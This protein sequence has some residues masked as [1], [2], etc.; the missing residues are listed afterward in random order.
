MKTLSK[1]TSIP[2]QIQARH[3]HFS[4]SSSFTVLPLHHLIQLEAPAMKSENWQ[5]I[6]VLSHI[7]QWCSKNNPHPQCLCS[8]PQQ[9]VEKCPNFVV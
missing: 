8:T 9:F 1:I 7:I 6:F 4:M 3:S 2:P 5:I